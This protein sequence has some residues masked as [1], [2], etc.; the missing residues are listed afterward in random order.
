MLQQFIKSYWSYYLELESQ[1]IETKRYVEFGQDN[2][3]TYSVEYLKLYQAACS[4]IDVVGKEIAQSVNPNFC[5]DNRTNIQKWGYEIQQQFPLIKDMQVSFVHEQTVHPF[6]NW[7]YEIYTNKK[8]SH[9]LRLVGGVKNVIPW[10]TSY[11]KVKH[12]RI[13]LVTGT[14]NFPLANQKNL[15]LAFSALFLMETLFIQW[16]IANES[17]QIEFEESRLFTI[18]E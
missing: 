5:I 10:W 14:Q 3:K 12:Q 7:E 13:G 9:N 18:I 8:G 17:T 15:I 16:L 6:H 2:A 1:F 11:N 4:E